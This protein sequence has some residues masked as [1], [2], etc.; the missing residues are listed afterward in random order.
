MKNFIPLITLVVFITSACA[1]EDFNQNKSEPNPSTVPVASNLLV[2]IDSTFIFP[3]NLFSGTTN[4][5]VARWNLSTKKGDQRISKLV[6]FPLLEN[7]IPAGSGL[8]NVSLYYNGSMIGTIQTFNG[9]DSLVYNLGS[10]MIILEGVIG[11]LEVRIDVRNST[12]MNY[13]AGTI[14]MSMSVPTGSSKEVSSGEINSSEIIFPKSKPVTI[15]SSEVMVFKNNSYSDTTLHSGVSNN[16]IA[17]FIIKNYSATE[18][19]R[20]IKVELGING[21]KNIGH[22]SNLSSIGLFTTLSTPVLVNNISVNTAVPPGATKII[23]IYA[24]ASLGSGTV[25]TTMKLSWI[26]L[27]SNFFQGSLIVTT[28]QIITFL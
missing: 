9:V 12:Y 27:S 23:D 13:L 14:M 24:D 21:T 1:K 20:L 5:I 15:F 18:S 19:V 7:V 26:G 10:Q 4:K 28:G 16:K 11:K 3:L 2:E 8:S 6:L 22:I 25:I 17:S